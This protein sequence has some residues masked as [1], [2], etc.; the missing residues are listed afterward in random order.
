MGEPVSTSAI[1]ADS[2]VVNPKMLAWGPGRVL[3][4][5][6]AKAVVCFRDAGADAP[7]D[8]LKTMVLR[9][10]ETSPVQSDAWLDNLLP[11]KNGKFQVTQP[12]VTSTRAGGFREAVRARLPRSGVPRARARPKQDAHELWQTRSARA[13]ARR[14]SRRAG[15]GALARHALASI[16]RAGVL[17]RAETA[18]LRAGLADAALAKR[19]WSALFALLASESLAEA[20]LA[21]YFETFSALAPRGKASAST[22]AVATSLPFLA[23]PDAFLI[24]RPDVSKSAAERLR[25]DLVYHAEP[26]PR[27]YGKLLRMASALLERLAPLGARDQ[28]D[29][30]FFLGEVARYGSSR[31]HV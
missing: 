27:T 24:L 17:N 11:F 10:L 6:G 12:R 13:R 31:A 15:S 8:G 9:A 7:G 25:F 5:E 20:P 3:Q 26:N 18:A 30:Q 28:F 23:R 21:P 2:Y 4:L 19:V 16:A 14:C 22:W 29:V 1:E